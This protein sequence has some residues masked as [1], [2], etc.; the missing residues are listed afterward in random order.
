MTFRLVDNDW[1]RELQPEQTLAEPGRGLYI[2][3]VGSQPNPHARVDE[4]GGD[5]ILLNR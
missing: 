4:V 2:R 3:P 5:A 1:G